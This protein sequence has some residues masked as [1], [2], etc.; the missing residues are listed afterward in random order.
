MKRSVFLSCALSILAISASAPAFARTNIDPNTD[1]K[2]YDNN[3]QETQIEPATEAP[4]TLMDQTTGQN[5]EQNNGQNI[6]QS[7]Q[8]LQDVK[9]ENTQQYLKP[10]SNS[11][12][13]TYNQDEVLKASE[14]FFGSTSGALANVVETVFKQQG[15]PVG[16]IQGTEIAAAIGAGL[17]YG[18]GTLVMKNGER[19]QVYWQGPS[20]GFDTGANAS[21]VFTLVY[22]LGNP[23]G[24]YRRYPGVEGAAFFIAGI[25]ATYQKAEGVTLAPIRTGVGFRT[26]ANAGY[27]AYSK[28]RR[29]LPF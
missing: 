21:K 14:N 2:V 22:N 3:Q 10:Q 15:S 24:I 11:Q 27:I 6:G 20:L 8:E 26:G 9:P 19:R 23:D 12:T 28:Q 4:A 13:N 18:K 1:L 29:I 7:P 25:S 17:R 16:Y 5:T